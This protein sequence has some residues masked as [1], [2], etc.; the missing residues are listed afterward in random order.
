MNKRWI[1]ESITKYVIHNLSLN[2]K[3]H[4]FINESMLSMNN[5]I[6]KWII[7][8]WKWINEY[9]NDQWMNYMIEFQEENLLLPL[10]FSYNSNNQIS[11]RNRILK[12][13][14]RFFKPDL[15]PSL[16][17]FSLNFTSRNES[18]SPFIIWYFFS[19]K[20]RKKEGNPKG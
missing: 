1:D 2:E 14:L 18:N 8:I 15:F 16:I 4:E 3:I 10:F 19:F 5:S 7:S 9:K 13:S 12:T 11:I 20:P 17:F 6:P